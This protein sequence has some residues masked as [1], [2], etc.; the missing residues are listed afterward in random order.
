MNTMEEWKDI[1]GCEGLYQ[2]SNYGRVKSCERI[3]I[4][5]N[6]RPFKVKECILN[7][8]ECH[9]YLYV[10]IRRDDLPI[11]QLVAKAFI[12]NPNN[13]NAVH[14]INHNKQD[15]RVE[16]L[17]WMDRGEHIA[18]HKRESGKNVYQYTMD[19]QLV[20]IW[21]NTRECD[22][23]GFFAS[24]VSNC[25]KGKYFDNRAKKWYN[26]PQYKVFRWSYVPL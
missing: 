3:T 10:T 20:K 2:V 24:P 9:E 23:N 13:Y 8:F 22:D 17:M 26:K 6:G 25:C 18:M 15:N 12:P 21:K 14:H 5:S 4:R 7:P 19:G 16:N 1:E 11:H